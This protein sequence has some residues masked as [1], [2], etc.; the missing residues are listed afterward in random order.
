M[1]AILKGIK[2][3]LTNVQARE[4]KARILGR[5]KHAELQAAIKLAIQGAY[6]VRRLR[7]GDIEGV[8]IPDQKAKERVLNQS[9]VEDCK[10]LRQD[11]PVKMP[12]ESLGI[13]VKHDKAPENEEVFKEICNATRRDQTLQPLRL[14]KS[15]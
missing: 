5:I 14:S 1:K 11:H 2:D 7:S 6:A 12:G 3:N 13:G 4:P 9:Q 8:T 15:T 10:A